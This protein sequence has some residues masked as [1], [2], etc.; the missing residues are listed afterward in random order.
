MKKLFFI[1]LILMCISCA[2]KTTTIEVAEKYDHITVKSVT[3]A[4]ENC[5][6]HERWWVPI[7]GV[8]VLAVR[9]DD[10]L[11]INRA[12]IMLTPSSLYTSE[13]RNKSVELLALHYLEY[14]KRT[15]PNNQWSLEKVKEINMPSG[16]E[17]DASKLIVIYEISSTA[18]RCTGDSCTRSISK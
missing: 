14:L 1:I 4:I 3:D 8:D 15:N 12:L 6:P 9:Y 2:A 10:C 18:T 13:I 5:N 16:E 17:G 7:G 11:D